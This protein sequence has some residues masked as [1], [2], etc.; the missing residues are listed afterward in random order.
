MPDLSATAELAGRH[1][2]IAQRQYLQQGQRLLG[3]LEGG[4]VLQNGLGFAVLRDH[5]RLTLF[6]QAQQ[7]FCGV[8]LQVTDR[9]DLR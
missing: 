4:H 6:G 8:G 2:L 5:Q 1:V 9:L 7:N 3:F